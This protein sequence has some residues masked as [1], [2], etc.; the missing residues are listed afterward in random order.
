ML[1]A[2]IAFHH[3][4][5]RHVES[6]IISLAIV[7]KNPANRAQHRHI[8]SQGGA[9]GRVSLEYDRFVRL[10]HIVGIHP[11]GHR[12]GGFSSGKGDLGARAISVGIGT[13]LGGA[14]EKAVVHRHCITCRLGQSDGPLHIE[15]ITGRRP[16]R[17]RRPTERDGGHEFTTGVVI[18]DLRRANGHGRNL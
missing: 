3:Q 13:R 14:R 10:I 9:L 12:F 1:A 15:G 7:V 16:F 5:A 8:A 17:Y 18:E 11:V 2:A 6:E 4:G